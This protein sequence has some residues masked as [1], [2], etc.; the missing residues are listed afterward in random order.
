MK[1]QPK[2]SFW[3]MWNVS[4]GFLGV[5]FGFALQN[6]NVSR[7]LQAFGADIH[8]LGFFW[9][10]APIAGIIIQPIIGG[11]SD[12]SWFKYL[13]GGRKGRRLPFILIGAL[14]AMAAM[15][16]MP[17]AGLFTAFIPAM[18]FGAMMLLLMDASFNVTMQPFRALVGDMVPKKQRDKGYAI[19]SFLINTG[20]VVG[21]LLPFILTH[22]GV[23]NEPGVGEKVAPSV[24]WSFYIGGA[25]LILTVLWTAFRT[26]EYSPEEYKEFHP[27]PEGKKEKEKMNLISLL[28]N[29]PK[30]MIQLALVQFFSWV[31]FYF[32][33]V[34]ATPAV[35]EHI[36]HSTDAQ[37]LAYNE[38]G[39]WVGVLFAAY[40]L[41]AA[42]FSIVM[43]GLVERFGRKS[44]YATA[45]VL[46][47]IG[48]AAFPF[49][50][51]KYTL[52]IAMAGVGIAWAAILSMP[53]AILSEVL[54][55]DKMGVYM[56]IFNFTIAGPQILAGLFGASIATAMGAP[57]WIIFAAGI[58]LLLGA[59]SVALVK[60]K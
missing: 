26:K 2:L 29:M 32:M 37:S 1:E 48:L 39:N 8:H 53:F 54:P 59:L 11:A 23:A 30:P 38:A 33:W 16:L 36:W 28:V 58:C 5:Q 46:G 20:A 34:Y 45:L 10:A 43:A 41:F 47:G 44:V 31:A 57:I 9:L 56:G 6:G 24:T 18:F 51:D 52:I 35:A 13:P 17:N 55:S 7:I 4:F 12:N 25:A 27:V 40:S 49:I 3:Q 50:H 42:L 14:A 60:Q 15:F 19:Q 21:S 22:L